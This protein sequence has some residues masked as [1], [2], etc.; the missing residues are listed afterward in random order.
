[1]I[2]AIIEEAKR[3]MNAVSQYEET[4]DKYQEIYEE[5]TDLLY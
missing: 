2:D 3:K 1:M 5:F 4:L